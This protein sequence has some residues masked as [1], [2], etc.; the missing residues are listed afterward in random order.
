[1]RNLPCELKRWPQMTSVTCGNWDVLPC[2]IEPY[3]CLTCPCHAAGQSQVPVGDTRPAAGGTAGAPLRTNSSPS[4]TRP[5]KKTKQLTTH[6]QFTDIFVD[7]GIY[8]MYFWR[9]RTLFECTH[10][11]VSFLLTKSVYLSRVHLVLD[12]LDDIALHSSVMAGFQHAPSV[13]H[14]M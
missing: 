14:N 5:T 11:H 8:C 4:H 2:P 10:A 13:G 1:M 7:S 9:P 3:S 6:K 12:V